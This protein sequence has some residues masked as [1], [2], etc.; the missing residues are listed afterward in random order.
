[1]ASNVFE[2]FLGLFAKVSYNNCTFIKLFLLKSLPTAF[3]LV[4][5]KYES[6]LTH[7]STLVRTWKEA[8]ET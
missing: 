8:K 3:G 1:M 2:L 5:F 6:Y 4:L 7:A